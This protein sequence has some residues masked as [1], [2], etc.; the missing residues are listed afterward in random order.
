MVTSIYGLLYYSLCIFVRQKKKTLQKSSLS[1]DTRQVNF[2]CPLALSLK[3]DSQRTGRGLGRL[4]T[5]STHNSQGPLVLHAWDQQNLCGR[6]SALTLAWAPAPKRTLSSARFTLLLT[7]V[8]CRPPDP[9]PQPQAELTLPPRGLQCR[10]PGTRTPCS[11]LSAGLDDELLWRDH[12]S[13]EQAHRP[14]QSKAKKRSS[15]QG[16]SVTLK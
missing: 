12:P 5:P 2:H 7:F 16:V 9:L 6:Q 1:K 4:L 13:P 3:P 11:H 15:S 8:S 14:L 10:S